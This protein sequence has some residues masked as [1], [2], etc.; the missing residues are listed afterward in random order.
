MIEDS[1]LQDEINDLERRQEDK[2]Y[3]CLEISNEWNVYGRIFMFCQDF[4]N[5]LLLK[6]RISDTIP[7]EIWKELLIQHEP[8]LYNETITDPHLKTNKNIPAFHT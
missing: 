7:E 6:L 1:L 2:I 5:S 4:G 3:L 8:K